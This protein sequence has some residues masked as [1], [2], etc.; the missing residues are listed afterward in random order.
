MSKF[1]W[2][3]PAGC[4]GPPCQDDYVTQLQDDVL[5]LLEEDGIDTETNDAIMK[6]ISAAE[7]KRVD[8][9]EVEYSAGL[10]AH[11]AAMEQMFPDQFSTRKTS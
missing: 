4:S 1:G 11:E 6:L 3:Y 2:S 5:A 8:A 7:R 10:D 9:A